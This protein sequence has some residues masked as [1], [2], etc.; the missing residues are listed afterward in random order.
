MEIVFEN[1][2]EQHDYWKICKDK[3]SFNK[4]LDVTSTDV[5]PIATYSN[6][7]FDSKDD[8]DYEFSCDVEDNEEIV[9][10]IVEIDEFFCSPDHDEE[11]RYQVNDNNDN[12]Y[13]DDE[14][15]FAVKG[16]IIWERLVF[17]MHSLRL[18]I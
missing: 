6:Y 17:I 8:T 14:N 18:T 3:A 16:I 12:S 15:T 1:D 11:Q 10:T 5:L 2:H 13:E 9:S 4:K 7:D